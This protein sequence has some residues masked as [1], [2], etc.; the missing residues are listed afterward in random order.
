MSQDSSIPGQ[1]DRAAP[2]GG[3]GNRL[4][5]L[6]IAGIGAAIIIAIGAGKNPWNDFFITPLINVLVLFNNV[7]FGQFGIAIIMF[8]LFMRLV[9]MPLTVRQFQSTKAMTAIQPKMQELQKKYKDPKRRQQETMKLY[10]EAGVNPMGC[11][12][13]MLIQMPIWI[14]LY[15]ALIIMVGGTPERLLDLSQRLYPWSYLNQSVPLETQ[16]LGLELGQTPDFIFHPLPLLVGITTYLQQKLTQTPGA[17]PQQQ[18]QMQM[19]SWM[20]PLM[21]VWIT[22]SVPSGL[23]LYWLVSNIASVFISFSVFGRRFAWRQLLPLPA[24]APKRQPKRE[25][26]EPV[27]VTVPTSEG[28]RKR[29]DHERRR[30]RRRGRRQDRR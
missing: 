5:I 11:I 22:L 30:G 9:T 23:G 24:A 21:F 19:M 18:Q 10:R 14:A 13:P 27:E 26:I 3:G 15:R 4:L 2:A 20:M 8:T 1:V 7:F 25:I 12:F 6:A 16:F 28:P 17:S 29:A